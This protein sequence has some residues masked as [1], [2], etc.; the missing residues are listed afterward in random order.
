MA[1]SC[2]GNKPAFWGRTRLC[3]PWVFHHSDSPKRSNGQWLRRTVGIQSREALASLAEA[4]HRIPLHP[5]TRDGGTTCVPNF[6][7]RS[8]CGPTTGKP[9]IDRIGEGLPTNPEVKRRED[10]RVLSERFQLA[11][12]QI[13]GG[14]VQ[15]VRRC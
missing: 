8:D 12:V 4:T 2:Q 14:A 5:T 13:C 3:L 15:L 10:F 7:C 11:L 1:Q 9:G 6:A